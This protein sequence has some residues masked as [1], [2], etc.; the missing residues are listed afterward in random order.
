MLEDVVIVCSGAFLRWHEG[1]EMTAG[2]VRANVSN[3]AS[4]VVNLFRPKNDVSNVQGHV[5]AQEGLQGC[6]NGKMGSGQHG[7]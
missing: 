6:D 1:Y 3:N 7:D 4:K 5:P 2:D